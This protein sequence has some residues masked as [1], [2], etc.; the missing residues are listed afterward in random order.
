MM[1]NEDKQFGDL[2]QALVEE[3]LRKCEGIGH[4]LVANFEQMRNLRDSIR[5][6]L[7]NDGLLRNKA[8]LRYQTIPTCCAVD[9]AYAVEKMLSNDIVAPQQLRLKG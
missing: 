8:I 3:L 1:M 5:R 6:Q 4:V 2:P 7:R 9:G